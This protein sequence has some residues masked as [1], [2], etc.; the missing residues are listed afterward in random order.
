MSDTATTVENAFEELLRRIIREEIV[1][2]LPKTDRDP[3]YE[4]V[5]GLYLSVKE[6]AQFSRL[7]CSTIRLYIRKGHLKARKVG[8]RVV[9]AKEDLQRF[10][11]LN[12]TGVIQH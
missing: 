5:T 2:L 9:I 11:S 1:P 6:A 3:S 12:P 8:R 7:A 4:Q 10:L